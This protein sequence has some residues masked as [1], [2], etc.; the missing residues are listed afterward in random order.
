MTDTTEDLM[1]SSKTSL[2]FFEGSSALTAFRQ[3]Q[4][5]TKIQKKFPKVTS[6]TATVVYFAEV[7]RS[8]TK[9]ALNCL[10]ALLPSANLSALADHDATVYVV[11]RFGTISPWSS[12]ATDIAKICDLD[13]LK[14]VEKGVRYHVDGEHTQDLLALLYDPMTESVVMNVAKLSVIFEA[15]SPQPLETIDILAEG[16]AALVAADQRL[17]LALSKTE[18]D[19]LVSAF[20]KLN[21][22]PTDVELMMFAQVNSEHCRHKI[23]NAH[24]NIDGVDQKESLFSMIRN[25]YKKNPDNALVAYSDNA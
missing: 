14:R 7:D 21:R 23:F 20:Q 13:F 18:I 1:T 15:H 25:T 3:Q 11:P 4:L 16:E 12:K 19:Y 5:L 24:W 8:V 6:I 22:N 2:Y 10:A 17:G 9:D